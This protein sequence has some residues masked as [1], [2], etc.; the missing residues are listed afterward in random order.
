[1]V[2]RL[3]VFLLFSRMESLKKWMCLRKKG[4]EKGTRE[5]VSLLMTL[6]GM[7]E[8]QFLYFP[9]TID[10][11]QIKFIYLFVAQTMIA[12]LFTKVAFHVMSGLIIELFF[13]NKSM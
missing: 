3:S 13:P 2:M 1:M 12:F 6:L 7:I 9:T 8:S 4:G 11:I 10:L 5:T